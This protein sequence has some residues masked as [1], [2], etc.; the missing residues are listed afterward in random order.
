L[1]FVPNF[2]GHGGQFFNDLGA[3][4][5]TVTNVGRK[6][7]QGEKSMQPVR[8]S[9]LGPFAYRANAIPTELAGL[10]PYHLTSAYE[11]DTMTHI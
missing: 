7:S 10:L 2:F 11:S 3:H 9:N 8:G 6:M 5:V 4:L 1:K